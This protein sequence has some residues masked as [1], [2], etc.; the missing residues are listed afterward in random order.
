VQAVQP[1][2]HGVTPTRYFGLL[3]G[4]RVLDV[5]RDIA[6]PHCAALRAEGTV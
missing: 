1:G 4:I 5:D 2:A 6:G 3:T